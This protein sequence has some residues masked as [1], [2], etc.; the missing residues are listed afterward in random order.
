MFPVMTPPPMCR[1]MWSI[2][3]LQWYFDFSYIWIIESWHSLGTVSIVT[4]YSL[5]GDVCVLLCKTYI[6]RV[7]LVWVKKLGK[8]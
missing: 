8:A 7:F 4:W 2:M 5:C 3:F 6:L 1:Q